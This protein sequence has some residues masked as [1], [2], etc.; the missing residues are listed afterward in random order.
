MSHS[1]ER[2]EKNCLNCNAVVHDRYCSICG[3]ENLEPQESAGH[4]IGH[5]FNDIT[6]FDGKFFSSMKY[7]VTKPGFL[8]A[9]YMAGRRGSYLN[10]VRMYV[11][12]SFV[13]FF[14]FFSFVVNEDTSIIKV[15]DAVEKT[16][17][18]NA[19][20]EKIVADS[21]LKP[22]NLNSDTILRSAKK[23]NNSNIVSSLFSRLKDYRDRK[24]YD[25][26][27][28]AGK[29]K[30]GFLERLLIRK[31]FSLKKRYGD[32]SDAMTQRFN[33]TLLHSIPQMFFLSLPLFALFLRLIY[34]RRKKYYYVAHGIFTIHL[35]V[36][37]YIVTLFAMLTSYLSNFSYLHWLDYVTNI[38][39]I[40]IFY[41]GYKA[42][43]NFYGQGRFKTIL[44]YL[45]LFFWLIFILMV[46]LIIMLFVSVYKL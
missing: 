6:H 14:I 33:E 31:K 46:L 35:Y 22:Y 23:R 32:D 7:L 1:K 39:I 36:F 4:L 42:M 24:E 41:Y 29:V 5:F 3:Q 2:K 37:I 20:A 9:E 15:N 21:V 16:D 10:P 12:T 43:R 34:F 44:K 27:V 40:Y 25:S 18:A 19:A 11:F 26:L 45:L 17:S 28:D 38:L 13:F 8:S 30:D